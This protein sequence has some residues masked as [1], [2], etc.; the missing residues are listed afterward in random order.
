M[1]VN[2]YE[3]GAVTF[4]LISVLL[5]AREKIW[6]WPLGLVNVT[7]FAIVFFQARLYASMALQLMFFGLCLYGWHSW[8]HGGAGH[9]QLQVSHAPRRALAWLLAAGATGAVVLGTTL[10]HHT[11]AS[12]PFIDAA[13]MSFSL[14]AQSMQA[15]K[16]VENW[17]VWFAVDI[18]YIGMYSSKQLYLTA[19]LSA[20][21]MGL[22]VF[23]F[24]TWRRSLP[25][26][27]PASRVT[28][29]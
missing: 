18:V 3:A 5:I 29:A 26:R 11:D 12:L 16:W 20:V 19:G 2:P 4:G 8:L 10:F 22:A 23:G 15:R 1:P 9:G 14:V 25:S 6:G 28:T 21:F 27:S 24:L 13:T 17:F 7:L